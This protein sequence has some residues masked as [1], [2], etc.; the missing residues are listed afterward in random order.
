VRFGK[1]TRTTKNWVTS[2]KQYRIYWRS[3]AYGIAL[4]PLFFAFVWD[5]SGWVF[6][7]DRRP[8]KTFTKA[9]SECEKNL[10]IRLNPET[11]KRTIAWKK[12]HGQINA[13]LCRGDL[14]IGPGEEE[15]E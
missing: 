10:A 12:S 6:A 9:V 3:E 13:R 7:T 14:P 2:D 5:G 11:D 8:Y 4:P 15:N 1:N